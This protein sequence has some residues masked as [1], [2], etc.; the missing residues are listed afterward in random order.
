MLINKF[1]I[2]KNYILFHL[3]LLFYKIGIAGGQKNYRRFIVL[4]T[5]RS[6]SNFLLGMLNSHS[7]VLAFGELFR[8][9]KTI[10]WDIDPYDRYLQSH[11][12]KRLSQKDPVAFLKNNVF[13]N[14]PA[15]TKAVGFKIFYYH[16]QDES[17]RHLWKF[18]RS[19][20]DINVIHLKRMNTLK[21][22]LS[23]KKAFLTN[24]WTKTSL[25]HE[26]R[27]SI[28][29]DYDECLENFNWTYNTQKQYD[30]LFQS[31][32]KLNVTYEDLAKNTDQEMERIQNFLGID[33]E[34][35]KPATIKQSNQPLPLAISNYSELKAKFKN[36]QWE[37]YF[38]D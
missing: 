38:E 29:L 24:K 15:K 30:I 21:T 37:A 7:Q 22:L 36:T 20:N 4:T 34:V 11:R 12:L 16:A 18:L 17:R 23:L 5:A 9:K 1:P 10:G 19:Q 8:E 25:E 2:Q 32:P 33:F 35:C 31:H 13:T 27:S 26:E 28:S 6:G 3:Y 14:F